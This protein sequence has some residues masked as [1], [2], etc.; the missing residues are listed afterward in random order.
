MTR[1][2]LLLALLSLPG[3]AFAGNDTLVCHVSGNGNVQELWVNANAEAA[4]LAHG[5]TAPG[6]WYLD[7][8]GDGVG[9]GP[10]VVA[11]TAPDGYVGVDGDCDDA[12]AG[13]NPGGE[14][15][16]GDGLDNDCDGEIDEDCWSVNF[17]SCPVPTETTVCE[18]DLVDGSI[19]CDN[20]TPIS[21]YPSFG[22]GL[23]YQLDMTDWTVAVPEFETSDP[24]GYWF[25]IGNSP[26]NNGWGGDGSQFSNDTE[27]FMYNNT[28]IVW[29]ND[30][31]GSYQA[32]TI[33]NSTDPAGDFVTAVV[34]DGYF[35]WESSTVAADLTTNDIFQID[36]NESDPQAGGLNDTQLYLSVDRVIQSSFRSGL[37]VDTL[38]VTFGR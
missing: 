28:A 30:I 11:C 27:M 2:L 14:E 25:S 38:T 5:D 6:T 29:S 19:A 9:D 23:V 35:G 20:G 17:G 4:H 21:L 33:P 37:G 32:L 7:A 12:D 36:G 13:T 22:S 24:S 3:L 31:S 8:D 10:G 34:C 16:C 26:S 1:S 15:V 18:I